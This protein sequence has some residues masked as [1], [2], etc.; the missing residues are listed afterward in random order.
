MYSKIMEEKILL[1]PNEVDL[2]FRYPLGR[3]Q[4]LARAG[5]IPHISLPDGELRFDREVIY[6]LLTR[7]Q[8]NVNKKA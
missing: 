4:R 6:E 2:I 3:S 8:M 1:K 5:K 7:Q